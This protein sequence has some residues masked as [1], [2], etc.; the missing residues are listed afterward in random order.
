[1]IKRKRLTEEELRYKFEG[2]A[3]YEPSLWYKRRGL[4]S[5]EWAIECKEKMHHNYV[6]LNDRKRDHLNGHLKASNLIKKF[7]LKSPKRE[8]HHFAGN[9]N[10]NTFIYLR[11]EMHKKLHFLYGKKNEDVGID[12]LMR[13]AEEI[14]LE[15]YAIVVYGKLV[16]CTENLHPLSHILEKYG[17][18]PVIVDP[19][20]TDLFM[21]EAQIFEG[22]LAEY[23]PLG[24]Q[25]PIL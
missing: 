2:I 14:L 7:G 8:I 25:P 15:G 20:S 6:Y 5:P 10:W 13:H 12:Q 1:M 11:K 24:P 22:E 18:S 19:T 4:E 3:S 9:Q 23:G 21:K 17:M 16:E